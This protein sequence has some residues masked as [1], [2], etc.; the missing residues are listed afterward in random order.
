[1]KVLILECVLGIKTFQIYF[2][3]FKSLKEIEENSKIVP[4]KFYKKGK[5][6][7][8]LLDSLPIIGFS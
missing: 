7:Q 8:N 4:K 1:M 5:I 3:I 6:N 2:N